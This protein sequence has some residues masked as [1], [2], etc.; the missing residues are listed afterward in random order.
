MTGVPNLTIGAVRLRPRGSRLC[1]FALLFQTALP[2][3]P[4]PQARA[5]N[6]PVPS[7]SPLYG[8]SAQR[9][10]DFDPGQGAGDHRDLPPCPVCQV[11]EHLNAFLAPVQGEVALPFPSIAADQVP[12]DLALP[13]TGVSSSCR[14]RAP[15]A[16][17]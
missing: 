4:M 9:Q 2:F 12:A 16:L 11:L 10:C 3:V 1:V 13:P 7:L 8:D 17:A 15:P 6:D 14:P 5:G